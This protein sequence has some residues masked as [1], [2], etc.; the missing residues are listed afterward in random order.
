ML[1]FKTTDIHIISADARFS[2]Q[3]LR[4]SQHHITQAFVHKGRAGL[5][6]EDVVLDTDKHRVHRILRISLVIGEN[7]D[8]RI[9]LVTAGDGI[10]HQPYAGTL[11]LA[12]RDKAAIIL[13]SP[14]DTIVDR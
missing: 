5:E 1:Q 6:A 13:V 7:D 4:E 2:I 3:V 9:G 11:D 10:I 12:S 14:D 8:I